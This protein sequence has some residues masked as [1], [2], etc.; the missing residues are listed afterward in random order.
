MIISCSI[1][2]TPPLQTLVQAQILMKLLI[3][4]LVV[5]EY[6]FTECN[7]IQFRLDSQVQTV[8]FENQ[9]TSTH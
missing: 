5:E 9:Q 4:Q 2:V 7:F 3:G 6:R 8:E 1:H